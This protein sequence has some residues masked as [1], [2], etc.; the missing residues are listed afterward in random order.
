MKKVKY[1][2]AKRKPR[3]L[4]NK[5]QSVKYQNIHTYKTVK[6]DSYQGKSL[7][8]EK[9]LLWNLNS[10]KVKAQTKILL[11]KKY[12]LTPKSSI[13]PMIFKYGNR[14]IIINLDNRITSYFNC[15]K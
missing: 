13:Q 8:L 9:Y 3:F 2:K 5:T 7:K 11:V 6:I 14:I 12:K 15:T 10:L 1:L 4:K